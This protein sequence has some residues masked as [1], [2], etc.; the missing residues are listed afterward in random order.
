MIRPGKR[1]EIYLF[2]ELFQEENT[3]LSG[4]VREQLTDCD[5][6]QDAY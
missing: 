1:K 4:S 6:R 3:E 2:Q 5:A